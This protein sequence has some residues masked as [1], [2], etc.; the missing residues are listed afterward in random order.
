[1]WYKQE[2]ELPCISWKQ[3]WPALLEVNQILPCLHAVGAVGGGIFQGGYRTHFNL[4]YTMH[5]FFTILNDMSITENV[6]GLC[7]NFFTF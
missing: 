4:E 6:V 1:M 5:V 3:L 7:P 2:I